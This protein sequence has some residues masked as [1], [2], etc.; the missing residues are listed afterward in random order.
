MTEAFKAG[1]KG[2]AVAAALMLAGAVSAQDAAATEPVSAT[3][4]EVAAT[5]S[6]AAGLPESLAGYARMPADPAVGQPVPKGINFQTPYSPVGHQARFVTDYLI[7]PLIIGISLLVVVLLAWVVVRYRAGAVETPSTRSHNVTIEIIWTLVPALILISLAFPSFRLLAKQYNVPGTELTVKVIGHQWYWTYEYPDYGDIS[8]DSVMLEKAEAEA[9]NEPYLLEVDNR[10]IV[11]VG[12]V[13]KLLITADDVIHSF[14]VPSLWVKM[15]AVPG[16]INQSWFQ[17]D[18][19][20]VYYGQCSELCGIKHGFMPIAVE[21]V[22]E[23]DFKRWV[24][25]RQLE[26]GMEL[27][28]PGIPVAQ[29]QSVESPAA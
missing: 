14:A 23:E 28:G 16:V 12:K 22:P 24:R 21:A 25:M 18:Q 13:V 9:N 5:A 4:A 20:G 1:L 7:N 17:I 27:T 8:H 15:D 6:G 11:P 29:N 19:P 3:S 26:D 10:L 2:L